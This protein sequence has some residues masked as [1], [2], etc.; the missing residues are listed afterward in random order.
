M[1]MGDRNLPDPLLL[2][3][4]II[5]Q[6][7]HNFSGIMVANGKKLM[8]FFHCFTCFIPSTPTVHFASTIKTVT[9]V[10][11]QG[12]LLLFS[13]IYRRMPTWMIST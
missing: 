2:P 6:D 4:P 8:W 7:L 9:M 10:W 5:R 3:P 12:I 11:G 13:K 1:T